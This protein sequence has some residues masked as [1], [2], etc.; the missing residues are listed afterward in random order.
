[1]SKILNQWKW[2]LGYALLITI[3][4]SC[5]TYN[6]AIGQYYGALSQGRFD[7]AA[8][9]LDRNKFLRYGRNKLLL[10]MEKGKTAFLQGRYQESNLYF[11]EADSFL[12]R[13]RR[14]KVWDQ[15]LG[16]L[17]NP[18]MQ[19]YAGEDFEKLLIHYYKALNYLQ[20]HQTED[21]VVEARR[22][23][24]SNYE[25]NDRKKDKTNKY[26]NDAFA[27]I[28]QGIIYE[29]AGDKNNAFIS[30]RNATDVFLRQPDKTYY[31]T[32]IPGQ[33]QEDL[34]RTAYQLGFTTELSY[35]EKEL[36]RKYS[37][38][39]ESDG[40]E[41]VIF[42]ENGLAPVKVENNFFF[43]ITERG[44]GNFMFTNPDQTIFIPFDFKLTSSDAGNRL[45]GL[46]AFRVAFPKYEEQ[47]LYYTGGHVQVNDTNN[48]PIPLEQVENINQLAFST[49]QERF[50]KEMALT[51]ARMAVKK[52]AE[53]EVKK[54]N[55]SLGQAVNL[56]GL[57]TEK[58]DTRNWQSLPHTIYYSRV[59]LKKGANKLSL[60]LSG[61]HGNKTVT[62]DVA[63]NGGL[64]TIHYSSLQKS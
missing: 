51:L 61:A 18:A 60:T 38:V 41:V 40:G 49:L 11:N 50:L 31:N 30:Y 62:L 13:G 48:I 6:D 42:W 54:D 46:E 45:K 9:Q 53:H 26:S 39:K 2:V 8:T 7:E 27:L 1:M 19:Q 28:M 43:T 23:S 17:V 32:P 15:T 44:P 4:V 16:I 33:L 10:L 36:G 12:E 25:L 59:P 37:P 64:Q 34:L 20:L 35:Y 63:G 21:A 57:L 3:P 47:P 14:N 29:S 5:R 58:A 56:L 22:I 24:L 52:L 55:E